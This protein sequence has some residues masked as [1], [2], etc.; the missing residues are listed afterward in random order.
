MTKEYEET[1]KYFEDKIK[2]YRKEIEKLREE[3]Q[4][5]GY[6][7]MIDVYKLKIC[8]NTNILNMLK[9]K[10]TEIEKYK[11]L[12]A[13]NLAKNLNDSLK[14]KE[15]AD[16]DLDDLNKGWQVELEKYK[17]LYN[18]ALDDSVITAHDNMKKDKEIQF[19]KDINKT[20]KDRHKQAEKSMKGQIEKKDKMLDLMAE[21]I[22]ERCLYIDNY[23]NSCEII[24]DSCNKRNNCKDCIKQYFER[25]ATN[26]G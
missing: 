4:F 12:L 25:I 15:K 5:E 22:S 26:D 18:K 11:N 14:A 23:G 6:G 16:T 20:E 13:S 21:W 19:Q 9:E 8:M 2:E 17:Q 1:I 3:G 10:D 24:Q 7:T